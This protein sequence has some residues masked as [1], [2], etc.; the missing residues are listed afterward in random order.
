VNVFVFDIETIPDV[1]T[2][3]RLNPQFA[4]L[5]DAEIAEALFTA[6]RQET[7]GSDFLP[8]QMQKIACISVVLRSGSRLKVWSLGEETSDEKEIITR[9]FAGIERYQPTL[10]SWNGSGF[11]LPLLHYRALLHG[12]VS[13][14]YWNV[15]EEDSNFRWNNYLNRYHYRHMDVMDMLSGYQSRTSAK[16]DD[17]ASM[18]GFPGKMGM[19][20]SQVWPEFLKGNLSKIRD[21]CESDVLN[22]Y[23]VFLRFELIRG[24]LTEDYYY[25]ELSRLHDWLLTA[26]K[27]SFT[28]FVTIW[29]KAA[30]ALS[31]V[32]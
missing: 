25:D 9:F 13:P 28:E 29:D 24:R 4:H 11:D 23:L 27:Q 7:N 8:L 2:A 6:R 18:L 5:T 1:Q 22:T 30:T 17:I 20:G 26:N 3:R 31:E 12:V 32:L 19:D 14:T 21:Y 10:V 15:G 16:L